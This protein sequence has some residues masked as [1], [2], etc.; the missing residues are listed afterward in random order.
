MALFHWLKDDMLVIFNL[1]PVSKQGLSNCK[2]R[3]RDRYKSLRLIKTKTTTPS[4]K[5]CKLQLK[6]F[7]REVL[8]KDLKFHDQHVLLVKNKCCDLNQNDESFITVS[9]F[10]RIGG[11]IYLLK[12]SCRA[13]KLDLASTIQGVL[14]LNSYFL[15]DSV[16]FKEG[17][18]TK[19]ND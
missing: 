3:A 9:K 8:K 7:G 18:L 1:Q 13:L 15:L 11:G 4:R 5:I 6:Q 17:E 16:R 19:K 2:I 12:L 10:E 14:E